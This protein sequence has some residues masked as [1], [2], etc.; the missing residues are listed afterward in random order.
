MFSQ[1]EAK[2]K[3][4]RCYKVQVFDLHPQNDDIK[5]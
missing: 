1:I 4:T 5:I 3:D 2:I